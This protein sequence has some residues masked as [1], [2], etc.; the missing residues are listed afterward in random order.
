MQLKGIENT[1]RFRYKNEQGLKIYCTNTKKDQ[2]IFNGF[3]HVFIVE[4]FLVCLLS[5]KLLLN[6]PSQY[7]LNYLHKTTDKKHSH[8]KSLTLYSSDNMNVRGNIL[9][10]ID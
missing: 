5:S 7:L 4:T 6:T 2:N 9:A 3:S 10:V 8:K 1:R